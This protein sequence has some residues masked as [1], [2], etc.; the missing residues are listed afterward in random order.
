MYK[1]YKNTKCTKFN[2]PENFYLYGTPLKYLYGWHQIF[3]WFLNIY[4]TKRF[5]YNNGIP[6]S[7]HYHEN[8]VIQ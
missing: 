7:S 4:P 3:D 5:H 6:H 2:A 8:H 1:L